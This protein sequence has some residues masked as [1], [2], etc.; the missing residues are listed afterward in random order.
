MKLICLFMFVVLVQVSASSYSQNTK[1]NVIGQ[2]LTLEK[3]FE[4][5]EDQSEFS[6]IYNLK[7]ID[8]SQKVDVDFKNERVEKILDR[9]LDGTDITYTVN[10]R[11]IVVHR[12]GEKDLLVTPV[13]QQKSVSG[14]VTD[15][16]GEPLP[17]VTV[18]I[19]GTTNGTVTN[20]DGEYT[21][22]NFP[23]GATL[24]F[25]FVG[26]RTQEVIV[27]SQTTVD[28][29]LLADAIG[30][31]EVVAVGYGIQ[32][33]ATL[34][35]SVAA[36]Q[37]DKIVRTKNENVQN[38]LTGKIP[39]LRVTQKSSEPGTFNA[40]MDV[41]GMGSPLVIIDGIPR[42]N[43]SKLD[44][45]DIES[46]SVL[47]DASAAV[48]GVKAANG[49][50]LVTTK[51][52]DGTKDKNVNVNYDG[53]M[54]WQMPSGLPRSVDAVDYIRIANELDMNKLDGAGT[55]RYPQELM[56]SYLSGE[57][58]STNWYDSVIRDFAP[59]TQHN[60]SVSGAGA[61][62]QYYT[63]I[64]YQ[65]Q[66]S[67]FKSENGFNYNKYN[68]RSNLKYNISKDLLFSINTS[69]IMDKRSKTQFGSNQIVRATWR[70]L[71]IDPIYA[72]NTPPYYYQTTISEANNPVAWIDQ[73]YVGYENYHNKTF[74]SS[75]SL[76]YN[77]PFIKGL[78]AK[79]L[80]SYDYSMNENKDYAKAYLQYNYNEENNKYSTFQHNSPSSITRSF[81]HVISSMYQISLNYENKFNFHNIKVLILS[82]GREQEADGFYASR[83][84]SID[85]DELFAGNADN[86]VAYMNPSQRYEFA[87]ESF[88][89]R[90]NYDFKGKYIAE[91]AFRLDGSSRFPEKKRWGFFPSASVGYRISEEGFWK[92]S[93][94]NI[95]DN[96]KVRA[97][98]GIMGDDSNVDYQFVSGYVYP[99]KASFFDGI[100]VNGVASTGIPN[101]DITWYESETI[102]FG[103][104]MDMW[105]GLL[106]STLEI[107]RRNRS[108]LLATRLQA[109]PG[110][111][112]AVLPQ[113]NLNS[114]KT[115]G[116]ELRLTHRNTIGEIKYSIDGHMALTRSKHV[117][118]ERADDRSTYHNWRGNNKNR[119]KGIWWGKDAGGQ[120]SSFEEIAEFPVFTDRSQ[121]PGDY[122]HKDWNGD[123]IVDDLDLHPIGYDSR[124]MLNFGLSMDL[125][126]RNF[127]VNMLWQGAAL[128]NV[129]YNEILRRPLQ[130]G[131]DNTL[132]MF[133]DRWHPVDP[134]ADPKDQKTE[135]IKG[136]FPMPGSWYPD[137]QSEFG[138]Y[139]NKYLRLKNIEIGYTFADSMLK[140]AG[141][142]D[143]RLYV[144]AYNLL[145][146][147][148]VDFVDPEH[149]EDNNGYMYPLNKTIT[150]GL[151]CKF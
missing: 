43:I 100:Y 95:I 88:I 102:N 80:Y 31:E 149:P 86:Q 24:Q 142:R 87:N 26:M 104:D 151:S 20:F 89:G 7:Q 33:K 96:F 134:L 92:E 108:G 127:D 73:D 48:Y 65:F 63:S 36:I 41:R 46:I 47:K 13:V 74:Q 59:Q 37:N 2:N 4:L 82:E 125:Y 21:L 71:P 61:K 60:F 52:G 16:N 75:A 124:P 103:L 40:A 9:L 69:L 147:S 139:N 14:I 90:M 55:W 91:A 112:G 135:F 76:S 17:G 137:D 56:D 70:Q 11:L 143:L 109:L 34:T 1:L 123:G 133:L 66:E 12:E 8:L 30:I 19:K 18:L 6:F 110:M 93:A 44:P 10:N 77:I 145:T 58:E 113:E 81:S 114:D 120:Y 79:A 62:V 22:T 38:M 106:G 28:I 15:E 105:N 29:T 128:S 67:F 132:E 97:S 85:L 54:T 32:K 27:D 115:E 141:I 49:V 129:F 117:Y 57:K 130:A 136:K 45:H 118:I 72:N 150:L 42:N 126:Y 146:F 94:L 116:F 78:K 51:K 83:Q 68:L 138:V 25:S 111:F 131:Y 144:G 101:F 5:I 107:F 119:Y 98:Y 84:L 50:I 122:Y 3:V 121:I 23:I 53:S 39:G 64:G 148:P 35:G 99:S 140:R